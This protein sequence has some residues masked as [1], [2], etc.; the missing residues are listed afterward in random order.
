MRHAKSSW[1][2]ASLEDHERPLSGRGRR[3]CRQMAKLLS[4]QE[5]MPDFILAS[6]AARAVETANL[7]I[8]NS[9]FDGSLELM[10]R[11]YLAEPSGYLD[12]L[13]EVPEGTE[14]VL[15]IGHN[16]GISDL[17]SELTGEEVDMPTAAIAKISVEEPELCQVCSSSRGRLLA[18]FR[19]PKDEKKKEKKKQKPA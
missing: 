10:R 4:D 9:G 2:D 5:M 8:E 18:F 19:P 15:I 6:T 12:V 11:L 17:A 14:T 16:P 1:R 13:T 3:A 7:L